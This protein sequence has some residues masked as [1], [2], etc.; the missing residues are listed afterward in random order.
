VRTTH[1]GVLTLLVTVCLDNYLA[2]ETV[3]RVDRA[4]GCT[5]PVGDEQILER[6]L[7]QALLV[8]HPDGRGQ[9]AVA[10]RDH[11]GRVQMGRAGAQ[12]VFGRAGIERRGVEV[13]E[14]CRWGDGD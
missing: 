6:G 11:G 7:V 9:G 2:S 10:R 12:R 5:L 8:C 3:S 4:L 1:G 13:R 14:I